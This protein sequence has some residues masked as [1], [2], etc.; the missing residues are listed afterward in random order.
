MVRF[1]SPTLLRLKS[2]R[3][4]GYFVV[5]ISWWTLTELAPVCRSPSCS[6]DL[7]STQMWSHKRWNRRKNHF[8]LP[9]ASVSQTAILGCIATRH[10]ADSWSTCHP[11]E[12]QVFL[13]RSAALSFGPSLCCYMTLFC[14]QLYGFAFA[15]VEPCQKSAHFS[16]LEKAEFP[17][18]NSPT[19]HLHPDF[20][21]LLKLPLCPSVPSSAPRYFK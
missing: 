2:P 21:V 12:P 9:F 15:F 19:N 14:H 13:C 1:P 5:W 7:N 18:N 16:S 17:L 4:S 11:P 8:P 10:T 3:S 6:G 20:W